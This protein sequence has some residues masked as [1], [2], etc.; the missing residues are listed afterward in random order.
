MSFL[1]DI[2]QFGSKVYDSVAGSKIASSIAKTAALAFIVNQVNNSLTKKSSPPDVARSPQPDRFVREQ[3]SPDT[4]NS[5]PVVYG[6]G[7]LKGMITDAKLSNDNKTM[8]YVITICEKTGIKLS[9]N[10][11]SVISFDKIYLNGNEVTFQSDGVTVQSVSDP[12]GNVDNS[13]NGFIKIYC[14]NN[15]GS[16]PVAPVGYTNGSLGWAYSVF[17]GWTPYH[18]MDKLVFAIVRVEYNKERNIT[19]LGEVE[20]KLTNTMT[21]PGDV[22]NDYMKNARYGADLTDAEIYQV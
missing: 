3:M 17:P 22:L 21:L 2:A 14:F 1:D 9:D 6:T 18:T 12:D 10:Q 8:W 5:I 19:S 16:G 13:M 4:N 15:G 20:F 11:D 7:F